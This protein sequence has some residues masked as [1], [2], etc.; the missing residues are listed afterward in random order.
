MN[1]DVHNHFAPQ[2]YIDI[3]LGQK[4]FPSIENLADG[5]RINVTPNWI[6][7]LQKGMFQLEQRLEDMDAGE[8]NLQVIS[9]IM[10]AGET[11]QDPGL[12]L[13]L[14]QAANE[15]LSRLVKRH[16]TRFLGMATLPLL[17]P[18]EAVQELDRAVNQLGLKAVMLTS[19]VGGQFLDREELEPVYQLAERLGVPIM[20]HPS[21]PVAAEHLQGWNLPSGVGFLVDTT[22]AMWR[23]ILSGVMERYPNLQFILC[24]LGSLIPYIFGRIGGMGRSGFGGRQGENPHPPGEYF[25]RV[26]VDTVSHHRPA[27]MCAHATLGVDKLMLGSDYPYQPVQPHMEDVKAL[28]IPES[29]KAAI[30]GDNA[31]RLFGIA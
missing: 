30:L 16:P 26:Y 12:N 4:G 18:Q 1:I 14:A 3:L 22:T 15:G 24:H 27:I 23:I 2:E 7:P 6:Y 5:Y 20:I 19:N 17:K 9:P 11:S 13:A 31:A 8:V 28:P 10:P 21:W 25:K 29:E